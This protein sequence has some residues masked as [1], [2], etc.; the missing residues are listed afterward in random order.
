MST[1]LEGM[2][3]ICMHVKRSE[4]TVLDWI[5]F[6]SFP[7]KKLGGI[8]VSDTDLIVIWKKKIISDNVDEAITPQNDIVQKEKKIDIKPIKQIKKAKRN[9]KKKK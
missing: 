5:R 4:A 3:Q 8:W 2:K 1:E 9:V 7:A 6:M